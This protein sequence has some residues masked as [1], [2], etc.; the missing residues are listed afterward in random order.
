MVKYWVQNVHIQAHPLVCV[1]KCSCFIA[2]QITIFMMDADDSKRKG[3]A[4]SKSN[5]ILF[6]VFYYLVDVDEDK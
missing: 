2:F 5:L 1:V 6:V 4:F 3:F